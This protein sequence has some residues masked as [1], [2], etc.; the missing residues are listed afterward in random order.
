[1]KNGTDKGQVALVLVLIMTVVSALAISLASRSTVDTKIQQTESQS[2]QALISAQTGLEQLIANPAASVVAPDSSY[3]AQTTNTGSESFDAGRVETGNTLELSLVGA[4]SKL[5]GFSIYWGPD[6]AN[7]S[8]TPAIFV[9]LID[10]D[11]KI[12]DAAY[13][14]TS[15]NGFIQAGNGSGGYAK[16][17]GII[18]LNNVAKLRITVLGAPALVKVIPNGA[19]FPTQITSIK[20]VGSV[21]SGSNTVKYGLQYDESANDTVPGIF[22]YALFSGGG[23]IQ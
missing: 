3:V 15:A 18:S 22:D 19:Y 6:V 14:Y 11:G 1:M 2:V 17:T 12:S 10:S 23:I 5:T 9:S 4:D 20:S 13:G 8:S 21:D 7:P 16:S